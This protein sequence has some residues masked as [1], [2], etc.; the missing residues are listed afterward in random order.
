MKFTELAK[1]VGDYNDMLYNDYDASVRYGCDC[2][3]GG[4]SYTSEGWDAMLTERG[5]AIQAAIDVCNSLGI[6]YDGVEP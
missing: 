1:L 6:E 4:D 5:E 2:G 3:C